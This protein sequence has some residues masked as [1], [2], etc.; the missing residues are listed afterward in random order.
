MT[1]IDERLVRCFAAALP[2]I[3]T[4]KIPLAAL[5]QAPG[6][7]S[8]ATVVLIALIDEEFGVRIDLESLPDLSY[9]AI[10]EYVKG[11]S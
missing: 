4:Q 5:N 11:R 2:D 6:W 9:K 3:D 1:D 8:L 10:S 7:D